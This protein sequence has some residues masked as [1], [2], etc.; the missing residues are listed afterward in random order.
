M[1][2]SGLDES[3][4]TDEL[5]EK[6]LFDG[7]D[8]TGETADVILVPGSRK[9]WLYRVPLAAELYRSGKAGKLLFSGGRVHTLYDEQVP[10][11]GSML[12][13]ARVLSLPEEDILTEQYAMDTAGNMR[14]SREML[15]RELPGCRRI[16]LVTAAYHMRRALMLAR[17]AMPQYEIF[18][19]PADKGSTTRK[20]WKR[21]EK[22]RNTARGECLKLAEYAKKGLID[23]MEVQL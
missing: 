14:L 6:L 12:V 18:P 11:Y 9:A 2:L 10:E 13:S 21:S 5:T 4:L 17:K 20:N 19:A 15:E 1:V 7:L 23:D 8:Y 22:G 16:I 3:S